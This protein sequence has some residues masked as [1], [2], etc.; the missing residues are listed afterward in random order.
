MMRDDLAMLKRAYDIFDEAG[1]VGTRRIGKKIARLLSDPDFFTAIF[2]PDT[3]GSSK[4]ELNAQI[5]RV[6]DAASKR[7]AIESIV[8]AI[9]DY[10]YWD[11]GRGT[12]CFLATLVNLGMA[13]ID[14]K[15]TD[16]GRAKDHNEIGGSDYERSMRKL[17]NGYAMLRRN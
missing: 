11:M 14:A 5:G 8:D 12:A 7:G 9:S 13:T 15:A 2:K 16:L 6:F 4:E 3:K 17:S 10:G 1:R